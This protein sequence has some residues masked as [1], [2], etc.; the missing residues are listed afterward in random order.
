[1]KKND[2]MAAFVQELTADQ[3]S[4]HD[5]CYLGYFLCFNRGEYYEAHDVLEHLWLQGETADSNFYKALIQIAG[6]Y[7]HLKK[8]YLRPH[9]HKDGRR[10]RPAVRLFALGRENLRPYLPRH[11]ELDV[12]GVSELCEKMMDR[13]ESSGF[14]Q[15]PWRPE[16]AP[17]LALRLP[18]D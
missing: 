15:N 2:R 8:Q 4:V 9:H 1:M 11:Q 10:L 18:S 12:A 16:T 14:Q 13:I 7:V 5:P 6:A 17:Q 3:A